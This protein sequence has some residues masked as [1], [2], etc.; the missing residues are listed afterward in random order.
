MDLVQ[1]VYHISSHFPKQEVYG[2]TSQTRRAAVSIA[3]NIAEGQGRCSKGDFRRPDPQRC[4]KGG[5]RWDRPSAVLL[6]GGPAF[7]NLG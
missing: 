2:L 1:Q 5:W 7:G 4:G 6:H 3:A